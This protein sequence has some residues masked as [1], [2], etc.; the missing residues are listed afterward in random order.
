M[1]NVDIYSSFC[2]LLLQ[3]FVL[4]IRCSLCYTMCRLKICCLI[5]IQ[6]DL[7]KMAPLIGIRSLR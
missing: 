2:P 6:E 4:L 1:D 5:Y 7:P 3:A